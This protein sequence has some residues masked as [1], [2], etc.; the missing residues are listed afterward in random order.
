MAAPKQPN[1]Q[2]N[3]K[4]SISFDNS[5]FETLVIGDNNTVNDCYSGRSR[6]S[7]QESSTIYENCE[8]P[9]TK[10]KRV[11]TTS[12]ISRDKDEDT[13][14]CNGLESAPVSSGKRDRQLE[15]SMN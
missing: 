7:S 1:S 8:S 3:G 6:A 15:Q 13:L 12:K 4:Y 11:N 5:K 10:G 9:V 2:Q 14:E